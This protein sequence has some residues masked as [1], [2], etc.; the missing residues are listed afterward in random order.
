M[1][2]T[3][4]SEC[5]FTYF[6]VGFWGRS[7]PNSFQNT[8]L[9]ARGDEMLRL[10]DFQAEIISTFPKAEILSSS[11]AI[12]EELK[13]KNEQFVQIFPLKPVLSE[14]DNFSRHFE[15]RRSYA[16]KEKNGL[17]HRWV[18]RRIFTTT[19]SFPG[20][21]ATAKVVNVKTIQLK[22]VS[23]RVKSLELFFIFLNCIKSEK[24]IESNQESTFCHLKF[25][26]LFFL[27]LSNV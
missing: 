18:E 14:E 8:V 19:D 23:F 1:K 22:P 26:I 24:K 7:F 11:E 13:N 25:Y 12:G 4:S 16:E 21:S 20:V 2:L 6:Y 15:H 27:V 10:E 17:E 3:T 9:I 5:S